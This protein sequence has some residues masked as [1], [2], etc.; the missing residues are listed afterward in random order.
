M[1]AMHHG[2]TMGCTSH[3]NGMC[4]QCWV[5]ATS[6]TYMCW[7]APHCHPFQDGYIQR[8]TS[9]STSV[10]AIRKRFLQV[11]NDD[12]SNYSKVCMRVCMRVYVCVL[13]LV[14]ALCG[15]HRVCSSGVCALWAR[16]TWWAT[17]LLH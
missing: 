1:Q 16:N 15:A 4:C 17:R 2:I 3:L 8:H 11:A 14:C 9:Q 12:D 13:C 7:C 5:A 10:E 6:I